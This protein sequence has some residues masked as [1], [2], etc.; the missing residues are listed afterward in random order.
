M[1]YLLKRKHDCFIKNIFIPPEFT[2]THRQ[3]PG[4]K[5]KHPTNQM[6]NRVFAVRTGDELF[7]IYPV[8]IKYLAL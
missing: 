7:P 8:N 2:L 5:R 6:I 3:V 1:I 4:T